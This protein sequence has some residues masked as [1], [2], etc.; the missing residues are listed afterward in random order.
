MQGASKVKTVAGAFQRYH[1]GGLLDPK[2]DA[3]GEVISARFNAKGRITLS[4]TFTAD[5]E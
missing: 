3:S 2:K 4:A 1:L 5:A